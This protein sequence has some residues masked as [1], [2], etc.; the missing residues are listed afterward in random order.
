M[1]KRRKNHNSTKEKSKETLEEAAIWVVDLFD[2]A[3]TGGF[4]EQ[5]SRGK[6]LAEAV[7]DLR[8]ILNVVKKKTTLDQDQ[9]D[10]VRRDRRC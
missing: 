4:I 1:A 10:Q 5:R 7:D 9:I 3:N 8:R 2:Q 6:I